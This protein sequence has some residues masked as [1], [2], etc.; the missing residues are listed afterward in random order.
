MR[1]LIESIRQLVKDSGESATIG[2]LLFMTLVFTV[3]S[4]A[5]AERAERL[6]ASPHSTGIQAPGIQARGAPAAYIDDRPAAENVRGA[7]EAD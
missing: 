5:L 1:V 7:S 6:A 2:L 3:V 4:S